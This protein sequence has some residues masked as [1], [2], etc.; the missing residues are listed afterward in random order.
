[1]YDGGVALAGVTP[2]Q[3]GW[4]T[5]DTDGFVPAKE[6]RVERM[7]PRGFKLIRNA[8]SQRERRAL[9]S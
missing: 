6:N 8:I 1:M 4:K 5:A 9:P 3:A 2:G 7:A